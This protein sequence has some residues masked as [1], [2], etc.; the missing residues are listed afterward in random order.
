[1]KYNTK[2]I[3]RKG[4][5]ASFYICF[6]REEELSKDNMRMFLKIHDSFT[7]TYSLT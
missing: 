2:K 3:L 7:V 6:V 1:M 5:I 4:R